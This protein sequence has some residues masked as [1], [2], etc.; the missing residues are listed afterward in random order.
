M[1]FEYL[2]P[3]PPPPLLNID[4]KVPVPPACPPMK[5]HEV[6]KPKSSDFQSELQTHALPQQDTPIPRSKMKTLNWNKIP[7]NKIVG[8]T[9][10]WTL[11]ADKNQHSPMTEINWDEMEGLFCQQVMQGSSK[12]VGNNSPNLERKPKKDNEVSSIRLI[13]VTCIQI[14]LFL[15]NTSGW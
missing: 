8:K 3:P 13:F 14:Y 10:I 5:N 2:V 15:D 4:N 1:Y 7:Q 6:T 12:L 11:V 9:N